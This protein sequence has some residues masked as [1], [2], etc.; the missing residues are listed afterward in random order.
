MVFG[1]IF[2]DLGLEMINLIPQKIRRIISIFFL[3]SEYRCLSGDGFYQEEQLSLS[4]DFSSYLL[5]SYLQVNLL[6][7][8]STSRCIARITEGISKGGPFA[9]TVE[10]AVPFAHP[11]YQ[12]APSQIKQLVL[13]INRFI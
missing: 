6:Y 11:S 8:S 4:L 7:R 9:P 10:Q 13:E 12:W 1:E 3:P 5:E 2:G